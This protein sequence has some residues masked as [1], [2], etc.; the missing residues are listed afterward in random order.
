[1][2]SK[3]FAYHYDVF[4]VAG[5][6]FKGFEFEQGFRHV[7]VIFFFLVFE[8]HAFGTELFKVSF[9]YQDLFQ[10]GYCFELKCKFEI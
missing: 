4:L 2:S 5:T 10:S 3:V 9:T 1:M 6:W 8:W 7:V